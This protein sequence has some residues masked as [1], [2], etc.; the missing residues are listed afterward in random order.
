[1]D[2]LVRIH[3]K[4]NADPAGTRVRPLRR[5]RAD[6]QESSV[7]RE[8]DITGDIELARNN[9]QVLAQTLSFTDPG[10]EDISKN[11]LI[12]EFYGKC[13][14]L[15]M[16]IMRHLQT[17][18]DPDMI[19]TL[20]DTNSEL[21]NTF[22]AYDDML[23][24]SALQ[25]AKSASTNIDVTAEDQGTTPQQTVPATHEVGSGENL[26]LSAPEQNETLIDFNTPTR[27]YPPSHTGQNQQT[28]ISGD[29]FDP[30][31]D[32]SQVHEPQSS[33]QTGTSLPP[34]LQPRRAE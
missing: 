22:K 18:S 30:F 31:S 21:V 14:D 1:M 32:D 5:D 2:E 20:L 17:A 26:E 7:P 9:C 33:L 8:E 4:L 10:K 16:T 34:P 6:T 24:Q 27:E 11:E 15:H 3:N 23:E 28:N 13:K 12:Q 25:N 19:S 29:P